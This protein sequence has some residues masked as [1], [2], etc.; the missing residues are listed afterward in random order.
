MNQQAAFDAETIR[1]EMLKNYRDYVIVDDGSTK[2][3]VLKAD[4]KNGDSEAALRAMDSEEYAA[5]CDEVPAD[6]RPGK[7]GSEDLDTV[8]DMRIERGTQVWHSG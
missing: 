2:F 5:W 8:V 1:M 7:P 3:P 4:L 6:L